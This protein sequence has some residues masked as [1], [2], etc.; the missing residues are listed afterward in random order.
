VYEDLK[1][2]LGNLKRNRVLRELVRMSISNSE[3][4]DAAGKK[5]K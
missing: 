2:L 5:K 3:E 1:D 4:L